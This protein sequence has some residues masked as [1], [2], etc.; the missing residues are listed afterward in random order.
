M[1]DTMRDKVREALIGARETI[2]RLT[3]GSHPALAAIDAALSSPKQEDN[4]R[5]LLSRARDLLSEFR[6]D[7]NVDALCKDID[8]YALGICPHECDECDSEHCPPLQPAAPAPEKGENCEAVMDDGRTRN[9]F[10]HDQYNEAPAQPAPSEEASTLLDSLS[11]EVAMMGD[12][13]VGVECKCDPEVGYECEACAIIG[14]RHN[15]DRAIAALR[16]R[17]DGKGGKA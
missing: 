11:R 5:D 3:M 10:I 9:Q 13:W 15:A 12:I 6:D 1:S 17:L 14:A 8:G 16:S 7:P 4:G 2:S